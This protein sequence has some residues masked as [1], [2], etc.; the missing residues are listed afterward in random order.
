MSS[1]RVTT[2]V[3]PQSLCINEA[4]GVW[5]TGHVAQ[6]QAWREEHLDGHVFAIITRA[7]STRRRGAGELRL[8]DATL[9]RIP[10][11]RRAPTALAFGAHPYCDVGRL[12]SASLRHALV[13]L[14]PIA[15]D[16]HG[17]IEVLDLRSASGLLTG[18][19]ASG[20]RVVADDVARFAVGANEVTILH[21]SPGGMFAA[22]F[23]D[24][25]DGFSD[26][27][28]TDPRGAPRRPLDA[29]PTGKMPKASVCPPVADEV[30]RVGSVVYREGGLLRRRFAA[31]PV[32]NDQVIVPCTEDELERGLLLGRYTRCDGANCLGASDRVSR[33]HALL[34]T[35]RGRTWLIDVG[36]T[37]GT[38]VLALDRGDVI[39]TLDDQMR[40]WPLGPGEGFRIGGVEVLLE[41]RG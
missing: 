36:S 19:Q 38:E 10:E 33:V 32:P 16:Q 15:D 6:L 4:E 18:P 14:W 35:R 21:A 9:V 37:N 7:I 30:T 24:D 11:G 3:H 27:A 25:L 40:L 31:E 13:L 29:E 28:R 2:L 12:R 17:A 26:L 22:D 20:E 1:T 41:I 8:V 34:I 23:P 5:W 39:A